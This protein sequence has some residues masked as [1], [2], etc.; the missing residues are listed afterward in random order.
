MSEHVLQIRL[1]GDLTIHRD[2]R[3]VELPPSKKT[4]ALLLYLVA[5]GRAHTRAALCDLLWDT[6]PGTASSSTRVHGR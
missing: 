4:R 5:T 2:G 3:A 1:L 6:E